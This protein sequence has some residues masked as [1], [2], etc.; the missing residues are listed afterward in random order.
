VISGPIIENTSQ[1]TDARCRSDQDV[2]TETEHRK[3]TA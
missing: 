2:D 3:K 1:K